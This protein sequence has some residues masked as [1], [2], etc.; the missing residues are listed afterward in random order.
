MSIA[1]GNL[2]LIKLINKAKGKSNI[3][4]SLSLFI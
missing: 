4:K 1:I 3:D 2:E